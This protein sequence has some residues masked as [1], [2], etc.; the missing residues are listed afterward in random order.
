MLTLP[1]SQAATARAALQKLARVLMIDATALD[2]SPSTRALA[3]ARARVAVSRHRSAAPLPGYLVR[4]LE[5]IDDAL[6]PHA[7][8][9]SL[10]ACTLLRADSL[11][12][13]SP[14]MITLD[15][16]GRLRVLITHLKT[17]LQPKQVIIDA[18]PGLC[19]PA[20]LWRRLC[21]QQTPDDMQQTWWPQTTDQWRAIVRDIVERAAA[22]APA[23]R[24]IPADMTGI[25]VHGLRRG[26][27][28]AL[29]RLGASTEQ[30]CR[31][32]GW[33]QG[34]E[35]R[36]LPPETAPPQPLGRPV[37]MVVDILRPHH[38]HSELRSELAATFVFDAAAAGQP[39]AHNILQA[40]H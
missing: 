23:L 36:Y 17:S 20:A 25:S 26:G 12:H 9:W 37:N 7:F 8:C 21:A 1:E 29:Y 16:G 33:A 15:A 18:G 30:I 28:H 11:A 40:R 4:L 5:P 34:S 32:G 10:A 3:A 13:V 6:L 19:A 22:A 38:S 27:A 39:W 31:A 35:R 24:G 2:Q 14:H